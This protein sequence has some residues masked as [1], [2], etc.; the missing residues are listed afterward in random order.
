MVGIRAL[1]ALLLGIAF[2]AILPFQA[3][4][5]DVVRLGAFNYPPFYH[6]ENG[7]I[8][9][10]AVDLVHELFGRMHMKTSLTMY[11]LT[12]ALKYAKEGR[13]DG[14]MILIKTKERA[15]YL[16]YTAPVMTVRGLIWSKADNG[17]C[18]VDFNRLEDLK[19]YKIGVTLGY[20][21]GQAMDDLLKT[22]RVEAVA[23]DYLNY[24]KLL[25]NRIDIFP[26]NEIVARGLFKQ[27]PE[28]RGQFV[29]SNRSFIEWELHMGI[30]KASGLV[31]E[32]NRINLT[33][34][35]L[36]AE[37]VLDRAVKKYTE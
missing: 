31:R 8:D 25:A 5:A 32:I 26:G 23:S 29:H 22:M 18:G 16:E 19:S 27:Y 14:V 20:S 34:A 4:S 15:S 1:I 35:D 17:G 37:G 13:L 12:R 7:K 3:K 6:E 9:G 11:P 10:I 36:K 30:S 24:K 28:F 2:L 21:Y 33:I